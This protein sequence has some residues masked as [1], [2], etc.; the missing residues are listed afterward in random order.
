V[1][2]NIYDFLRNQKIVKQRFH[3]EEGFVSHPLVKEKSIL[4][5]DFHLNIAS[6]AMESSTL[7][8]GKRRWGGS[9]PGSAGSGTFIYLNWEKSH[10][11]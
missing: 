4:A 7:V 6:S 3:V 11:S 8:Q 1:Q 10:I 9:F 2:T 5:K